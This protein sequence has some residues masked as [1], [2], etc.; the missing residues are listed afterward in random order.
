VLENLRYALRIDGYE[1]ALE[2]CLEALRTVGLYARRHLMAKQLSQG[3]RRRI[4]MARM[5]LAKRVL[6][7]LDEP[8][9]AL[10]SQGV[11]LFIS[12]LR[13][14]LKGNGMAVV[15]THH[16]LEIWPSAQ[17]LTLQ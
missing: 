16:A 6:W 5:T 2:P 14:H 1:I 4:G 8:T 7:L 15:T 3:Q 9:T 17:E 10:D 12:T 11:D 13:S